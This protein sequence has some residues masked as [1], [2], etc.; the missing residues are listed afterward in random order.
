MSKDGN[1]HIC[2]SRL[3]RSRCCV[4]GLCSRCLRSMLVF[5]MYGMVCVLGF[6]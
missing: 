5:L 4:W 2:Y 6:L 1:F 3:Y